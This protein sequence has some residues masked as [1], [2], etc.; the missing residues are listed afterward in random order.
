MK[1]WQLELYQF[2]TKTTAVEHARTRFQ[3]DS[4]GST[5]DHRATEGAALSK[6]EAVTTVRSRRSDATN[7]KAIRTT[8]GA[9][10]SERPGFSAM[11]KIQKIF[12]VAATVVAAKLSTQATTAITTK[13]T[14]MMNGAKMKDILTF[15]RDGAVIF[16]ESSCVGGVPAVK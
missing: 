5:S 16:L 4:N 9:R 1:K 14:K 12:L 8:T 11:G 13:A 7:T 3:E 10:T 6:E 2:V 15:L